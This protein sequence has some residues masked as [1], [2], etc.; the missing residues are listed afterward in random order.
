MAQQDCSCKVS[1]ASATQRMVKLNAIERCR[2]NRCRSFRPYHGSRFPRNRW[3][4]RFRRRTCGE[5]L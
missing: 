1:Q 5:R 2:R 3:R 4:S